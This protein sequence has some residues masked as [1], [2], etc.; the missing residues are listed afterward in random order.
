[1]A[2]ATSPAGRVLKGAAKLLLGLLLLVLLILAAFRAAAAWR[3]TETTPPAGLAMV[4]TPYGRVAAEVRGAGAPV[5]LIHGSA[6][7]SGFWKDVTGHVAKNGRR[8]IA[9]DIPPFGWSDRDPQRRYDRVTQAERLAAVLR[10]VGAGPA[11]VVGHSFGAGAA[12]E[13]ALR[14]PELVARLV[15]VDAALGPLDRG[16]GDPAAA[17]ALRFGPLAQ[18]VTAATL[19]DPWATGPLLRSFLAR[20]AAAEPWLATVRAPMRRSGTTAAYAA[21][22]PSLFATADGALSRRSS[23]IAAI[24]VPVSLIWGRDDTVTPE[25]QGRRLQRLTRARSFALLPGVG[26]IPH[27]ED[28]ALFLAALDDA[29]DEGSGAR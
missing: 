4:P 14:H 16:G 2:A 7:W 8:A 5:L 3:E 1:M 21:W 10:R 17:K 19:T 24:R 27:I 13:L 25:A 12:T 22:L 6:G 11:I 26:H 9:V 20:K 15:L 18:A 23:A 28:P 29:L